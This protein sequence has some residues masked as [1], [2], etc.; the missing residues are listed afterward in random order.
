M[1]R[2]EIIEKFVK[3]SERYPVITYTDMK[4]TIHSLIQQFLTG[5]LS[6]RHP[7]EE[8]HALYELD[9]TSLAEK[10][11]IIVLSVLRFPRFPMRECIDKP[12]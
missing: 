3:T 12:S 10:L 6:F 5:K 8:E 7:E 2:A 11:Q 4:K 9:S 1:R